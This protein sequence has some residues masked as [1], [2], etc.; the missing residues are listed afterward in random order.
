MQNRKQHKKQKPIYIA[1][2]KY[3]RLILRAKS[4]QKISEVN[5]TFEKEEMAAE[6]D[7]TEERRNRGLVP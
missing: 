6:K 1:E 2:T 7:D 5:I 4:C 3:G